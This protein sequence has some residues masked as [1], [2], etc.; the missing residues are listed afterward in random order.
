MPKIAQL[1]SLL[2]RQGRKSQTAQLVV[3]F[4]FV[5]AFNHKLTQI[6]FRNLA[7][8]RRTMIDFELVVA[9]WLIRDVGR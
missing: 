5:Q 6:P 2:L 9:A 8:R 1:R 4:G 7:S 3:V